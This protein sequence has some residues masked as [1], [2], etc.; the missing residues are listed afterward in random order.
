MNDRML[1]EQ[2]QVTLDSAEDYVKQELGGEGTG[3]DYWHIYRVVQTAEKIAIAEGADLFICKIAA[4]LHDIADEKLNTSKEAGMSKVESWLTEHDVSEENKAHVLEIIGNMSYNGGHNPPMRTL[5]GKVVQDADRLDAIGAISVARAFVYAG[6]KGHLIYDPE[7]KPREEMTKEQYR[8]G[9][10]TAINHFYEKL[11][12]LKDL[13]NTR[14]G[15]KLAEKRHLF[16][17]QYL[18]QFF[19]EW[20]G[21][22]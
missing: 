17:E 3:H 6:S 22:V 2:E 16:M 18:D 4:Y 10:N 7:V 5:E 11:L 19:E 1:T 8:T 12:K 15:M 14:Y 13:M 20:E 9:K 21:K